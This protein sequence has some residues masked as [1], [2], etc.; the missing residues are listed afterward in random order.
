MTGASN[1]TT[2]TYDFNLTAPTEIKWL[3]S[4]DSKNGL[5]LIYISRTADICPATIG[6][7]GWAT[8]YAPYALD[9]STVE[10]L[11]AYIA[12]L[13]ENTVTITAVEDVPANTGVVLHGAQGTYNIPF[14]ASSETVQGDL[15]GNATAATAYDAFSGYTLY[16][17]GMSGSDVQFRPVTSGS[18]AAGKPFLK[19]AGSGAVKAFNVVFEGSTGISTVQ[20]SGFKVQDSAIFNLAGQRISMAQKGIYLVNGKKVMVK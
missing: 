14:A 4:G 12:K 19:V 1:G 6:E 8:L 7:T 16:G 18:I 10:G 5:D 20:G 17:L 9:F 11:T 15:Q 3:A 13:S 2:K